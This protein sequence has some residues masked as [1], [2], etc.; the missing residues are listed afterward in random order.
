MCE[1]CCALSKS[2][3]RSYV[4]IICTGPSLSQIRA[5]AVHTYHTRF[6]PLSV[7]FPPSFPTLTYTSS[8]PIAFVQPPLGLK[9]SIQDPTDS[10][11]HST[12]MYSD[13]QRGGHDGNWSSDLL[14]VSPAFPTPTQS[15][16]R[17]VRLARRLGG[18]KAHARWVTDCHE[19]FQYVSICLKCIQVCFWKDG[20]IS[21]RPGNGALPIRT[22][23]GSG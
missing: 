1:L 12:A 8:L 13:V 15:N 4:W 10:T 6:F 22:Q 7:I 20:N 17:S 19:L 23:N 14:W 5:L 16:H 2:G 9:T 18:A 21:L 3:S 11:K